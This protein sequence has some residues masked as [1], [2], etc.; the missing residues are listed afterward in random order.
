ME[1]KKITFDS[2]IRGVIFIVL[3]VGFLMLLNRLSSVLLPFFIA[4]LIA[5]MI[6]P[7]VKFFQFKM[8]MRNR[9]LS[10][11]SALLLIVAIGFGIFIL[12]VPPMIEEFG[13]VNQILFK[14]LSSD[15]NH[16]SQI[17]QTL[18]GFIHENLDIDTINKFFNEETFVDTL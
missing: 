7:L 12:L 1:K 11:F 13:R 18:S 6:Y 9:A 3:F 14:Y 8:R 17:P 10:T 4:W 5:Y 16:S 15:L 2:F